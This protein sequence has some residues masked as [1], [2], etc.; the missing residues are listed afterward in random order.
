MKIACGLKFSFEKEGEKRELWKFIRIG[1]DSDE[2]ECE[3]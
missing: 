3:Y 2:N 1:N